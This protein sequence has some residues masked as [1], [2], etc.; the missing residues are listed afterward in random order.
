MYFDPYDPQDMAKVVNELLT[1]EGLRKELIKKGHEQVKKYN[2]RNTAEVT[3]SVF[4]NVLK[5]L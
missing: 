4:N 5:N 1:N 3:L 2:W